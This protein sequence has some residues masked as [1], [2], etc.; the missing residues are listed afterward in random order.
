MASLFDQALDLAKTGVL[1]K[2]APG[3]LSATPPSVAGDGSMHPAGERQAVV[4]N[5]TTPAPAG[6]VGMDWKPWAIGGAVL[7][8]VALAVVLVRK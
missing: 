7:A 1:A 5:P 2:Y 6:A 8:A 4:A 3:A